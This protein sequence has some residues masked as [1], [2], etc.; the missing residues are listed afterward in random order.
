LRVLKGLSSIDSP[1]D[2]GRMCNVTIAFCLSV[3]V[4]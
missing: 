1:V 3:H 2:T 4:L